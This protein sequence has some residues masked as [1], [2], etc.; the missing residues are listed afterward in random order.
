MS[1][2]LDEVS[3]IPYLRH[4]NR[5][6]YRLTGISAE[7]ACLLSAWCPGQRRHDFYSGCYSGTQET[8]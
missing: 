8:V 1:E 3:K 2:P 5:G 7:G 4:Q 6:D